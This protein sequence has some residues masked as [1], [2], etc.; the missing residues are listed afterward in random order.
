MFQF[1][2]GFLKL[3]IYKIMSFANRDD[4]AFSLV[5]QMRFI[6]FSSWTYFWRLTAQYWI[7]EVRLCTLILFLILEKE[8]S[9]SHWKLLWFCQLYYVKVC[10][11][12]T[13]LIESFYHEWMMNFAKCCSSS[14]E[15]IMCFY[16]LFYNI[17]Y[18]MIYH[19]HWL[20]M[21]DHSCI[22][23]INPT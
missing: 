9:V 13:Q 11:T 23:E 21:L 3:L 15:V 17:L 4:F 8:P 19:I 6:S 1:L 14:I 22:S 20:N 10:S 12:S 2:M 7:G 16:T 5:L 18:S